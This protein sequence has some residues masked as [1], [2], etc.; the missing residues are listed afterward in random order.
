MKKIIISSVLTIALCLSLIAGST[1]ALFTSETGANIA[2]NSATV[3]VTAS[4]ENLVATLGNAG[5]SAEVDAQGQLV[6][7]NLAPMDKVEFDIVVDNESNIAIAYKVTSNAAEFFGGAL[8][9]T[10]DA[11]LNVWNDVTTA[12]GPIDP[13]HVVV[14]FLNADNNNSYMG[15]TAAISFAVEAV[16]GNGVTEVADADALADA[17]TAGGTVALTQDITVTDTI[18]VAKD[19]VIDLGNHSINAANN[20]SRP[21]K[22]A[23]GA[24]LT[25]DASSATDPVEVG[26]YGLVEVPAGI[27]AD[28]TING[29]TFAGTTDN[30]SLI[31][32][33]DGG[34]ADDVVNVTLNNV[35]YVDNGTGRFL[36]SNAFEGTANVTINGCSVTANNSAGL[37]LTNTNLTMKDTQIN[38][39]GV[40]F[41]VSYGSTA[42]LENVTIAVIEPSITV[43][44]APAAALAVSYGGV[45]TLTNCTINIQE[46]YSTPAFTTYTTG[47]SIT[48]IDCEGTQTYRCYPLA[49]NAYADSTIT[50]DGVVVASDTLN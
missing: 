30:G 48:A 15:K 41:E 13:I 2:V 32:L 12:G 23:E 25:I 7:T 24:S 42:T 43:G 22:M 38:T 45:A 49:S 35:T 47:G 8:K 19:T 21:L 11:G 10:T 31:K 9:V 6:L 33:R 5:T 1:F 27:S 37:T 39:A 16:Q 18:T 20:T 36:D 3:R 29:G 14:E 17:I 34:D 4:I 44:S 40:A 26:A 50:I 28:V 46:G